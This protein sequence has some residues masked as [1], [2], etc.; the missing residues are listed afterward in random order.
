MEK[1]EDYMSEKFLLE[2]P[3]DKK[4]INGPQK[5]KFEDKK[6]TKKVVERERLEEGLNQPLDRT[7]K[8]M[9]S[10]R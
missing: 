6:P 8:G 3:A 1:E 7:N 10:T 4:K 2:I 9:R 5:R